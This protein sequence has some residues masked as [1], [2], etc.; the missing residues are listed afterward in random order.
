MG[1]LLVSEFEVTLAAL[2]VAYLLY[3]LVRPW[4]SKRWRRE[5]ESDES[6]DDE[7]DPVDG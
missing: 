7:G 5:I 3:G 2:F 6:D 1:L 4:V